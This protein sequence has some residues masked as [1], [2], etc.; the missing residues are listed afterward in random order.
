MKPLLTYRPKSPDTN[1]GGY[2]YFFNGQEGD[3]EVFGEVA[4]F[5]YE[6]RQYDS[7]LGRW[8]SIDPKWNEYPG[9]SPYVFC[10]GSPVMLIDPKGKEVST[11]TNEKGEVVEQYDDGN[12]GIYVHT[13]SEIDAY[14]NK[15]E[16]LKN[17][18]SQLKGYTLC[19]SS[20]S[21]GDKIDFDSYKAKEWMQTFEGA[22]NLSFASPLSAMLFYASEA[23][24]GGIF[25]PKSHFKNG[26]QLSEGIYISPR[27]LGNFAAGY[28]GKVVGLSKERTLASFGAFQLSGNNK[29]VFLLNYHKLYTEA[30][31]FQRNEHP[32][33]QQTY[34][35]KTISNLFQR[36][37]YENIRTLDDF[38]KKYQDIWK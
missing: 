31:E 5:G 2:R 12:L 30:L 29:K 25:D 32:P 3:N 33:F 22:F 16:M 11:H 14:Y 19:E 37:G 8:W 36:L 15:G 13:Q 20:F 6:F 28:F 7:R 34:G 17:N 21:K 38:N 4:N 27:D 9:V 10:N 23:G 1:I 26:S 24:N 35:E 18:V